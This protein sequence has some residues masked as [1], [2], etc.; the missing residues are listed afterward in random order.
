MWKK[1]NIESLTFL[2]KK[3]D[4]DTVFYSV[5]FNLLHFEPGLVHDCMA[6]LVSSLPVQTGVLTY[7]LERLCDRIIPDLHF[8]TIQK[9]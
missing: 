4:V 2:K 6:L 1:L 9:L 8:C 3:V 7:T 5:P